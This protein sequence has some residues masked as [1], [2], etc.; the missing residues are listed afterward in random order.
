M[1]KGY[2]YRMQIA[3]AHMTA[4]NDLYVITFYQEGIKI[5]ENKRTLILNNHTFR[6]S[7]VLALPKENLIMNQMDEAIKNGTAVFVFGSNLA[8]ARAQGAAAYAVK[9]WGAHYGRGSGSHRLAYALPTKDRGSTP[10]PCN[11]SG[12]TFWTS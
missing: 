8:G 9:H 1:R 6:G 12:H 10:C 2:E 11:S 7:S 3:H 5:P 4:G